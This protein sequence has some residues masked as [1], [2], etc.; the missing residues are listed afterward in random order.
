MD[1]RVNVLKV[2]VKTLPL[3]KTSSNNNLRKNTPSI[4][5]IKTRNIPLPSANRKN[6]VKS[7]Y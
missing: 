5:K 4:V 6:I 2:R 7:R 1:N 3:E